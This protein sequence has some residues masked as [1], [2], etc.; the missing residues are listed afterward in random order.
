MLMQGNAD[1]LVKTTLGEGYA[2]ETAEV[3]G[4]TLHYVRGGQGPAVILI[5]GFPQDWF[6]YHAIMP[7]LAKQFTVIAI[8]L[9]GVGGSAATPDGYDAATMAG[10]VYRLALTL[11]LEGVYVVGHDIGGMVTYAF[12]RRYPHIAR[13]A[14]ILDVPIP[15]IEGWDEIDGDASSWHVRFMQI[16]ELPERLVIGRQADFLG[17]FYNFGKFAPEDVAHYL[18]AY[19]TPEQ[20]HAAFEMYR[21]FPA[22]KQ[23]NATQDGRNDV[24]VFVG[25]GERSPFAKIVPKIAEGLRTRGFSQVESGLIPGGVHYLIEDQPETVAELI[26]RYASRY[27]DSSR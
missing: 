1:T 17:Y 2:S 12:V 11:K 5:H 7:R 23:F 16:P 6:E 4:T 26:E 19:A 8:D 27:S 25:S 24:P 15:G 10:D 13:G 14:M 22:N 21:A 3:N 18:E 9:R 20:L